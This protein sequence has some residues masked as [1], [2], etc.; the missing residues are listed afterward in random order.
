VRRILYD[1]TGA[2][3]HY[4]TGAGVLFD[5]TNAP[6]S[7]VQDVQVLNRAGRVVA[8]FNGA[9]AWDG[10]GV[11]AFVKGAKPQGGWCCP[12]PRRYARNRPRRPRRAT[13]FCNSV[14]PHL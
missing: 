9:F 6:V 11:L 8:W 13:R 1:R 12:K 4:L 14:S 10:S 7:S 3:Q 5:L 2:P